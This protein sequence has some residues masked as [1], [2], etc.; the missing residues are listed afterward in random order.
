MLGNAAFNYIRIKGFCMNFSKSIIID[1]SSCVVNSCV[2]FPSISAKRKNVN[3]RRV[4]LETRVTASST[5]R[6]SAAVDWYRCKQIK[7]RQKQSDLMSKTEKVGKLGDCYK[8][9][10]LKEI[11]EEYRNIMFVYN[12]VRFNN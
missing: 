9:G 4:L 2:Y 7:A 10:V 3:L 12:L 6:D 8:N 5:L 11:L 1:V